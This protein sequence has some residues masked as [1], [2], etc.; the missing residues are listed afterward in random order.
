MHA[1]QVHLFL[2][3]NSL[4]E[5][6]KPKCRPIQTFTSREYIDLSSKD[7]WVLQFSLGNVFKEINFWI[8]ISTNSGT[9]KYNMPSFA[10]EI[11]LPLQVTYA[12]AYLCR[13]DLPTFASEIC[14][15]YMNATI[16]FFYSNYTRFVTLSWRLYSDSV[17]V[18]RWQ[19]ENRKTII[20]L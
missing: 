19:V 4:V 18:I 13:W 7:D 11:C 2:L 14:F 15:W 3:Q 6:S 8:A 9:H 10:S 12:Y 17:F 1:S 5:A 16:Y 20:T